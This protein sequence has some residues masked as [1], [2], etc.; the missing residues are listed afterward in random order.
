MVETPVHQS[1]KKSHVTGNSAQVTS[2]DTPI[3]LPVDCVVSEWKSYGECDRSCG[4]GVKRRQR[5]IEVAQ[6]GTGRGCPELIEEKI[7]NTG[8]CVGNS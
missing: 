7:C 3:S 5:I 1:R 8:L 4:G 2:P 6:V